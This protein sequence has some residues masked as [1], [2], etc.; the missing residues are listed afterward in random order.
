MYHKIHHFTSLHLS[1]LMIPFKTQKPGKMSEIFSRLNSLIQ[2]DIDLWPT[3]NL[4][5]MAILI[6]PH[7]PWFYKFGFV[8]F[9][10]FSKYIIFQRKVCHFIHCLLTWKKMRIAVWRRKFEVS[11]PVRHFHKSWL[12]K[13]F[14][15]VPFCDKW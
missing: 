13:M 7:V 9:F 3:L 12:I 14:C 2:A 1:F 5:L 15:Y 10:S 11:L 8:S 6:N 4:K